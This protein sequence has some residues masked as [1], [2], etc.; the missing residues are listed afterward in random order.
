[1]KIYMNKWLEKKKEIG[2]VRENWVNR[3][4]GRGRERKNNKRDQPKYS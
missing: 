2:S 3:I 1:M 4:M